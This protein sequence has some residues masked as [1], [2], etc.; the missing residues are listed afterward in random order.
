[1]I[2]HRADA[3]IIGAGFGGSLTALILDRLGLCVVLI[4]RGRHPR[5]AIGESSTPLADM[6]LEALAARYDLPRVAPL[7]RYGRWR[8]TYP[9][10]A[11]G[12]KRGFSYFH[13]T[14]GLPFEPRDDHAN[15][16]L[17]AANS[18]DDVA[19]THWYRADVDAFFVNEA[20]SAGLVYVDETTLE[21]I[22]SNA[23]GTWRL[24]G[25]RNSEPVQIEAAFLIDATGGANPLAGAVEIGSDTESL[26]TNARTLFGHFVG[27]KEWGGLYGAAVGRS[28]D[29][30]FRCDD[31]ALHHMFDG[32]WMWVLRFCNGIT[33]AGFVL[34]A[35]RF[36]LDAHRAPA[37][38]WHSLLA[39]FPSIAAQFADA[40]LALPFRE[41]QRTARLQ[42]LVGRAA[43]PGW[44][45]LPAAAFFVDPLHSTGIAHTLCAVE[46]LTHVV[47][48]HWATPPLADAMHDYDQ[49]LR[50]EA[51][52]IDRLVHGCHAALGRFDLM[53]SYAMC[54]FAAA[55]YSEHRLR[56]GRG[57]SSGFLHAN[58]ARFQS[59]VAACYE[60]LLGCV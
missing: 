51:L 4:E 20:R 24:S 21:E 60:D 32:G 10:M 54:Y 11:C 5:F 53:A 9:D 3:A 41:I 44:A 46:R 45:M 57:D 1:M 19:D 58:D 59:V 33:S 14:S 28:C 37:D 27:V 36:P 43:G 52:W 7:A 40:R 55:T 18:S 23:G 35:R 16:L 22:E 15:E 31:A 56:S 29:H 47:G 17:V 2:H 12:C 39:R 13:H 30:P 38:E 34:D 26:R 8:A 25:R 6:T 42:R 50:R 48:A 49:S